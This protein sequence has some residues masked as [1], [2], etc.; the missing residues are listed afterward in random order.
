MVANALW[1]TPILL[2]PGV[3]M[4]VLSTSIRYG[5]IHEEFHHMLKEDSKRAS[6]LSKNLLTRSLLFRNAQ[7]ILYVSVGLF[8]LATLIG[9]IASFWTMSSE[10]ITIFL[11]FL[12]VAAVLYSVVELVRESI[13]SLDIIREHKQEIDIKKK[14]NS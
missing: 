3:A 12:G 6:H 9:G 8:S 1:L 7:V 10:W 4:L 13:V 14:S 5:Q 11:L 2:L